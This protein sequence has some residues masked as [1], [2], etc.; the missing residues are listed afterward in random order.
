MKVKLSV[1]FSDEIIKA[2]MEEQELASEDEALGFMRGFYENE[3][4]GQPLEEVKIEA[5]KESEDTE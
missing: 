3:F 2:L 4:R 1:V 5:I